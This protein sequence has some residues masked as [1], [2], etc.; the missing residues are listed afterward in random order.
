MPAE[1]L[2]RTEI[3]A[4]IAARNLPTMGGAGASESVTAWIK[5]MVEDTT[6]IHVADLAEIAAQGVRKW[7]FRPTAADFHELGEPMRDLRI[8]AVRIDRLRTEIASRGPEPVALP[9]PEPSDRDLDALNA[10]GAPLGMSWDKSGTLTRIEPRRARY[11]FVPLMVPTP[12]QLAEVA[13]ILANKP[14][15]E[16]MTITDSDYSAL[17]MATQRMAG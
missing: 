11:P 10:W 1:Q 4:R 12:E 15:V 14:R 8:E 7:R 6:D 16:K 9:A 5:F 3:I 17:G 2:A 13:R